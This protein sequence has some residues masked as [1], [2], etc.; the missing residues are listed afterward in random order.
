MHFV[1]DVQMCGCV[2]Y[3]GGNTWVFSPSEK[4]QM[5]DSGG[6]SFVG[7]GDFSK[8]ARVEI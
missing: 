2:I 4:V 3:C 7:A 1:N 5:S 8:G 6:N